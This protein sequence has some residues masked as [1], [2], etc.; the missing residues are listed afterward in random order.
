MSVISRR[1][2]AAAITAVTMITAP[3]AARAAD[4]AQGS[5]LMT[6][7]PIED[8]PVT[9]ATSW[10]LRGDLGVASDVQV[11][12]GPKTL[13]ATKGFPNAWSLGLGFGYKFNDWVRADMTLDGRATRAFNGNSTLSACPETIVNGVVNSWTPCF[14]W[15]QARISNATL[16]F[17]L[18]ADLGTWYGLTPY[19]GVGIGVNDVFQKAAQN[20]F[21]ANGMPAQ[22]TIQ[23]SN[24]YFPRYFI[25]M[26][27]ARS[28]STFQFAG[29]LMAG[30]SYA[31]TPNLSIDVGGR[32]M[33]LGSITSMWTTSGYSEVKSNTTKEVRI[34]FRYMPD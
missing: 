24:P 2:A 12:L 26:N 13:P 11:N 1:I 34:G 21:L 29:A 28:Y 6:G 25:N 16:L 31:V 5:S 3:L 20:W 32:F 27:Q 22:Y 30:V 7:P 4:M 19:V 14:D 8:G 33:R 9:F 15:V 10:Y 17:N 23:D 18:Y